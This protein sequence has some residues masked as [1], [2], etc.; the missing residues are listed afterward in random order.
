[1]LHLAKGNLI[2]FKRP[3]LLVEITTDNLKIEFYGGERV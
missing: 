2:V 1:L 3:A